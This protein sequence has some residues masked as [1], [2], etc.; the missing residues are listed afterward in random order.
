MVRPAH[1]TQCLTHAPVTEG[2]LEAGVALHAES[3]QTELLLE[4][5]RIRGYERGHASSQTV[6]IDFVGHVQ[7][8]GAELAAKTFSFSLL[9]I[10]DH[11]R[12]L[13]SHKVHTNPFTLVDYVCLFFRFSSMCVCI[14]TSGISLS[15]RRKGTFFTLC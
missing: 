9:E 4:N 11:A 10:T 13:N 14:F 2:S 6:Q 7:A 15:L 3:S 5:D 12:S 8:A 1:A